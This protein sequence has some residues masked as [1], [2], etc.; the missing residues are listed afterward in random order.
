MAHTHQAQREGIQRENV[1]DDRLRA[2]PNYKF[3]YIHWPGQ[4]ELVN[5]GGKHELLPRVRKISLMPGSNGVGWRR[6]DSTDPADVDLSM[7]YLWLEKEGATRIDPVR[8]PVCYTGDDGELFM[9]DEPGYLW[10]MGLADG[11]KL[12][13]DPWDNPTQKR[14]AKGGVDWSGRDVEGFRAWRSMLA[15][16]GIIPPPEPEDLTALIELQSIRVERHTK[17]AA[18]NPAIQKRVE[19]EQ[20]RLSAML[21]EQKVRFE[22]MPKR[23]APKSKKGRK[24]E[25]DE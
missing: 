22:K 18:G 25:S 17:R 20:G 9:D 5:D 12:Y 6:Q 8:T 24:R 19:M 14:G 3:L 11:H 10:S 21:A 16:E 23:K 1:R 4:W 13:I 15:A 2:K 7:L